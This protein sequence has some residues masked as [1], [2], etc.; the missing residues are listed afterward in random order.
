M[1]AMRMSRGIDDARVTAWVNLLPDLPQTLQELSDI[2]LVEYSEG[3]WHP[4]DKGWL[5]G[6][7]LY[8]RLLDLAS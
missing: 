4:T 2:G 6:N 1:L 8:G 3:A 5:C 7:E